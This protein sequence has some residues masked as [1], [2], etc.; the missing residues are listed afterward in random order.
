MSFLCAGVIPSEKTGEMGGSVRNYTSEGSASQDSDN[1]LPSDRKLAHALG[2]KQFA[3][4]ACVAHCVTSAS[5]DAL[6]D[7]LVLGYILPS[8]NTTCRHGG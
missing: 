6:R 2:N 7:N 5:A 4:L 1:K 3:I 8:V